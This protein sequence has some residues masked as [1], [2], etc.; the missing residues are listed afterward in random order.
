MLLFLGIALLLAGASL[1]G[2]GQLN[3]WVQAQ[4][5]YLSAGE[6]A[7][8]LLRDLSASATP[9]RVAGLDRAPDPVSEPSPEPALAQGRLPG[10]NPTAVIVPLPTATFVTRSHATA[11]P[12][13][14]AAPSPT[15]VPSATSSPTATPPPPAVRIRI[16]ALG[17]DRSIIELQVAR[18]PKTGTTKLNLNG[19]LRTRGTDLVGHWAGSSRPG[20]PGNTILVGHNYG[21]GYNGVFLFVGRLKAGQPVYVINQAGET[22]TYRVTT[23]KSVRWIRKNQQELQMHQAYLSMGGEERLTLVTCGGATWEPFPDRVYVVAV[24]VR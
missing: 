1:L 4:D 11:T 2:L 23:V 16:P 19:L 3:R 13:P 20:Q 7:A 18:D 9:I 6:S 21:Y 24:P 10:G 22:F 17:I 12:S 5:R 15:P 8:L 14:T